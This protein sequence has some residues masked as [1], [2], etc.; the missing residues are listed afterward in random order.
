[1]NDLTTRQERC[2][3]LGFVY[4]RAPDDHWVECTPEQAIEF[5]RDALNIDV[6]WAATHSLPAT[7]KREPTYV[8]IG[9]M[10]ERSRPRRDEEPTYHHGCAD[11]VELCQI[12]NA[13]V[14]G[15]PYRAWPVFKVEYRA[16]GE[17]SAHNATGEG[18]R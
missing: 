7:E 13:S 12:L 3:E 10:S 16:S 5:M 11:G 9:M 15:G 6:R 4:G 18:G 8:Q 17:R 14:T 1:M 2:I